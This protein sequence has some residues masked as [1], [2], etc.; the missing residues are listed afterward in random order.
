MLLEIRKYTGENTYLDQCCK[1]GVVFGVVRA[2]GRGNL[3]SVMLNT[4]KPSSQGARPSLTLGKTRLD[5]RQTPAENDKN[6]Q[7]HGRVQL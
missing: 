4:R 5:K 6:D 3:H 7:W 1:L 2:A